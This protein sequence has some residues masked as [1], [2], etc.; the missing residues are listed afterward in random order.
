M[1][2]VTSN[3]GVEESSEE[4]YKVEGFYWKEHGAKKLLAKEKKGLF[5]AKSPFFRGKDRGLI[6]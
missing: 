5:W 2:W 4:L 6:K 1:N 3:L